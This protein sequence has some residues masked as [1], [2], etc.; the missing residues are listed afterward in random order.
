MP[1]VPAPDPVWGRNDEQG[2][3]ADDPAGEFE[4]DHPYG[5]E[6]S[7]H[8]EVDDPS[9]WDD[10]IYAVTGPVEAH[11]RGVDFGLLL[12]RLGALAMV[13]HGL[14]KAMDMPTFTQA[15]AANAVGAQAPEFI[16][17]LIMLA[18]VALPLLVAVGLFTRPAA[19][20]TA[21]MM[22]IIWVLMIALRLDYT[23]LEEHGGL[24]G[25][26]A[27]LHVVISLPLAFTGAGRWS[28]DS[29]RT[30]GRP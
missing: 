5:H 4:Q 6:G 28:V 17:W 24:S 2:E 18:Q 16:A 13:P 8:R 25:E 23:L 27:L 7:Y 19:F 26:T 3:V 22:A 20:L 9:G 29:M 10:D 12:L 11:G 14:H 21:S 1:G 15:V 30:A